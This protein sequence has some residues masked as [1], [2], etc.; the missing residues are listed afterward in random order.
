M[1][2]QTNK[3]DFIVTHLSVDVQTNDGDV[4]VTDLSVD[5]QTSPPAS[6]RVKTLVTDLRSGQNWTVKGKWQKWIF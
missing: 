4:Y 6:S 5:V 2:V 3:C 1:S